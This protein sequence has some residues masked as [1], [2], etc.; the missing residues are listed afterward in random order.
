MSSDNCC[1]TDFIS[2]VSLVEY[3][4]NNNQE[5]E[6]KSLSDIIDSNKIL[7]PFTSKHYD[8]DYDSY[9]NEFCSD[10]N[11]STQKSSNSVKEDTLIENSN[12]EGII[13][14]LQ[15]KFDEDILQNSLQ[16]I[17]KRDKLMSKE[18]MNK[19]FLSRLCKRIYHTM[20]LEITN[21]NKKEF[22]KIPPNYK[23]PT[24]KQIVD[25]FSANLKQI[26]EKEH[27]N[28]AIYFTETGNTYLHIPI[29]SWAKIYFTNEF[30][31]LDLIEIS[32]KL[33]KKFY[34]KGVSKY[35]KKYVK[36]NA[37]LIGS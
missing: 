2:S 22:K 35:L 5:E 19:K 14:D 4:N 18:S 3:N 23:S 8:N 17:E 30:F 29:K 31:I 27:M 28:S 15:N 9:Y 36:Y 25:F 33:S 37:E 1:F 20:L 34:P 32:Q 7:D 11:V 16:N 13:N 12:S 24:F 6:G 26:Y 21:E 10:D